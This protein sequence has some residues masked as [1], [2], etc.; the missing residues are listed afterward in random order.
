MFVQNHIS[1]P[2]FTSLNCPIAK[3]TYTTALRKISIGE[4]TQKDLPD[5]IKLF[6]RQLLNSAKHSDWCKDK[7]SLREFKNQMSQSQW[8]KDIKIYLMNLLK[9]EDGNS[10]ILVARD[11]IEDKVI[12]YATME[13]LDNAPLPTGIIQNY[14]IDYNYRQ[15][16]DIGFYMLYKL[17]N[18]ARGFFNKIIVN[19]HAWGENVYNN[20][21]YQECSVKDEEL[22]NRRFAPDTYKPWFYKQLY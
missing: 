16:P 9:K 21:G 14:H 13:S 18:S 8:I 15:E 19:N 17:T 5:V 22:L 4:I 20:L 12:G 1:N 3:E 10:T 11:E 7:R 6:K 2:M